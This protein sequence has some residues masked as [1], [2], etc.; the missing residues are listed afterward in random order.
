[1]GRLT[2]AVLGGA[3]LLGPA[4]AAFAEA[5]PA[6]A[7]ALKQPQVVIPVHPFLD[8]AWGECM[9]APPVHRGPLRRTGH[10]D[11]RAESDLAWRMDRAASRCLEGPRME[12]HLVL[13]VTVDSR[14]RISHFERE[15]G[16]SGNLVACAGYALG[17]G[18]DLIGSGPGRLTIGYFMGRGGTHPAVPPAENPLVP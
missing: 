16:P 14:G 15:D 1:M 8:L 3:A 18:S 10:I 12:G 7:A 6:V 13:A 17:S 11:G 4:V 9:P 5:P 2:L